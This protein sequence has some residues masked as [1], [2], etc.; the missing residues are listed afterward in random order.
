M[1]LEGEGEAWR[2][3]AECKENLF[4][5]LWEAILSHPTAGHRISLHT[6]RTIRTLT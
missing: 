3:E 1:N 6:T 4:G 5:D 2:E